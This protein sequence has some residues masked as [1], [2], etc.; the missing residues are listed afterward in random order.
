MRKHQ[1]DFVLLQTLSPKS[2]A[3]AHCYGIFWSPQGLKGSVNQVLCVLVVVCP[4]YLP[5]MLSIAS[6]HPHLLAL[7][8]LFFTFLAVLVGYS[9]QLFGCVQCNGH[10]FCSETLILTFFFS[11]KDNFEA[12][13]KK[14][15]SL[16]PVAHFDPKIHRQSALFWCVLESTGRG[17][18]RQLGATCS[19]L[20]CPRSCVSCVS[21]F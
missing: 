2:I 5:S 20:T 1:L 10:N 13:E 8:W 3:R 4:M 17:R 18:I 9:T 6:W 15:T 21:T 14:S 12:N 7:H 16:H 11:W 19:V